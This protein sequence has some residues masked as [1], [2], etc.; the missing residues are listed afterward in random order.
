MSKRKLVTLTI[1]VMVPEKM[2]LTQVRREVKTRINDVGAYYDAF[3][4]GLPDTAE[5]QNGYIWIRAA[6]TKTEVRS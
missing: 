4:I 3:S 2:S 5:D 1:N 6:I